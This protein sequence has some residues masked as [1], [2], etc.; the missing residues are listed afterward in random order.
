MR[1]HF[2]NGW[3]PLHR[4]AVLANLHGGGGKFCKVV[5]GRSWSLLLVVRDRSMPSV[6]EGQRPTMRQAIDDADRGRG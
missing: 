4:I 3:I 2:F 5:S 1:R 6:P